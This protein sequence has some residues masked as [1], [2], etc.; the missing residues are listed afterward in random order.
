MATKRER[1]DSAAEEDREPKRPRFGDEEREDARE[2][3]GGGT[4]VREPTPTVTTPELVRSAQFSFEDASA[5]LIAENTAFRVHK[6]LLAGKSSVLAAMFDQPPTQ[7]FDGLP[8]YRLE[9][10]KR[11]ISTTLTVLYN[12]WQ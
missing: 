9:H 10:T 6:S 4:A 1:E 8:A 3:M 11:E 2:E 5:V 7:L 12:G